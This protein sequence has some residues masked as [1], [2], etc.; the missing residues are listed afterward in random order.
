[1]MNLR[2]SRETSHPQAGVAVRNRS[3]PT[4]S[5]SLLVVHCSHASPG[6]QLSLEQVALNR[7]M[8]S[9]TPIAYLS[10]RKEANTP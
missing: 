5:R 4:R 9:S 8:P 3:A 2:A 1:M 6:F 7:G 10:S